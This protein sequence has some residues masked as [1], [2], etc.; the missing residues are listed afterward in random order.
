MSKII[1]Y[2]DGFNLYF[3]MKAKYGDKYL[4]LDIEALSESLI[5]PKDDLL[6]TKYFTSR[7]TNN[8]PKEKRQRTYL[9]ALLYGTH[10]EIFYGRFKVIANEIVCHNCGHT[11]DLVNEKMTDVQIATQLLTDAFT[12]KFERAIIISGDTDLIPAIVAVKK[13]HPGKEIGVYFPPERHSRELEGYADFH[14]IIGKTK[15][16]ESQLPPNIKKP[17]GYVL[18]RPDIWS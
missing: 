15:L 18:K 9:D 10:T 16:R 12:D 6:T 4:W 1:T 8:P 7:V 2:I 13:H 3:G 14:G 11:S 5:R 17:D